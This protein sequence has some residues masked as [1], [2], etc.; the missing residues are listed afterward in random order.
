MN[1]TV[2]YHAMTWPDLVCTEPGEDDIHC[3]LFSLD[4]AAG[5]DALSEDECMRAAKFRFEKDRS[6]FVAGRAARRNIL[7]AYLGV[8][9]QSLIFEEGPQGRPSLKEA[10]LSFNMS[11]SN[12]WAL[13]AV[14]KA[15]VL[16]V[17]LEEVIG[18][19]DL[20]DVAA[21]QFSSAEQV[22]LATLCGD[23]W[24]KGFFN[25]WTRKEAVVKAVGQGLSMPL[26][27]F[28]VSLLPGAQAVIHR[29]ENAASPAANW[30]LIAFSPLNGYCAAI[31][32]NLAAPNLHFFRAAAP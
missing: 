29:A 9:P 21:D 7:A 8:P 12:S 4:D 1:E 32:N 15:P 27:C 20:V 22:E 2:S 16:G 28:D 23:Q 10:A 26:D 24:T 14:S 3:W 6:R 30:S 31:A 11:R 25:C 5:T 19:D 17:D 13:L 18:R